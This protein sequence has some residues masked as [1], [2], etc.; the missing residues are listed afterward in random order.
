MFDRTA[1]RD[2]TFH[3][4]DDKYHC[5]MKVTYLENGKTID[6]VELK[7][8]YL[9]D[10]NGGPSEIEIICPELLYVEKTHPLSEAIE[11]AAWDEMNETE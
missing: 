6:A 5:E 2:F 10:P 3:L 7:R 4:G 8:C 1:E 11:K 9:V